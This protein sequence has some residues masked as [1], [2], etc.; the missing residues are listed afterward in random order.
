MNI[1]ISRNMAVNDKLSPYEIR[2]RINI[3]E[4]SVSKGLKKYGPK[5]E[6]FDS[7][8]ASPDV[9][10]MRVQSAINIRVFNDVTN[11]KEKKKFD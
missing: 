8:K 2:E 3:Y 4:K 10:F 1:M 5:V 6:K 9:L 11:R 7:S